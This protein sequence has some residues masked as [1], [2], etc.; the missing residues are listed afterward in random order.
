MKCQLEDDLQ[1]TYAK[2]CAVK[3]AFSKFVF[4]IRFKLEEK[5]TSSEHTS[6]VSRLKDVMQLKFKIEMATFDGPMKWK[7]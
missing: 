7:N 2:Y 5:K 6:P 1:H 4:V 3:K